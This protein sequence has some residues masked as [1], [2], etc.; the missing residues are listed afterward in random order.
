MAGW[1]PHYTESGV[2]KGFEPLCF[3]PAY[4]ARG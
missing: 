3:G 4:V 1:T 2:D